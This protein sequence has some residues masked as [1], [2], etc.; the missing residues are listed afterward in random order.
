MSRVS[1]MTAQKQSGS[2]ATINGMCEPDHPTKMFRSADTETH[3]LGIQ[4]GRFYRGLQEPLVSYAPVDRH[5]GVRQA[6]RVP[7]REVL[8]RHDCDGN[9]FVRH[10]VCVL[11]CTGATQRARHSALRVELLKHEKARRTES[12]L[13]R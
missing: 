7:C 10:D 13:S 11:C 8:R 2:R 3:P 6:I 4:R 5:I 12:L 1:N 9:P